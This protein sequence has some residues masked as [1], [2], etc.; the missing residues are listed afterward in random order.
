MKL[1]LCV[2]K[3]KKVTSASPPEMSGRVNEVQ[4][5]PPVSR[6]SADIPWLQPRYTSGSMGGLYG[7]RDPAE[8][9]YAPLA[10]AKLSVVQ[11]QSKRL[12]KFVH[13]SDPSRRCHCLARKAR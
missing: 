5:A 10:K 7:G 9:D 2:K 11:T 3:K 1:G 6:T 12:G 13:M 4:R 8:S